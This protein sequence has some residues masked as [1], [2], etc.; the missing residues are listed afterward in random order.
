MDNYIQ[1][2][3]K[4]EQQETGKTQNQTEEERK[5]EIFLKG[6]LKR[7]KDNKNYI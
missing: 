1:K 6:M 5:N 7:M 2:R 4:E 3:R